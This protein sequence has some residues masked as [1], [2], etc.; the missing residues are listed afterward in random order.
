MKQETKQIWFNQC[1]KR[2]DWALS[3]C[4]ND[5]ARWTHRGHI[6]NECMRYRQC[7]GKMREKICTVGVGYGSLDKLCVC[8]LC[9]F[10]V[11]RPLFA[12]FSLSAEVIL[13]NAF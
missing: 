6:A 9:L 12:F 2:T 13:F 8:A 5:G 7:I 3:K 1:G 4:S 11:S 10:T